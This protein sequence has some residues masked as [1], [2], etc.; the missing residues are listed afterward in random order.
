M[1]G[2][3]D[4]SGASGLL[5]AHVYSKIGVEIHAHT[6]GPTISPKFSN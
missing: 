1:L 6:D 4:L 2:F 3:I 5:L